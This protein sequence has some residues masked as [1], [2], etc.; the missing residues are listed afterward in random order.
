MF[1][2][3]HDLLGTVV[4]E[5][6]DGGARR[7]VG[8]GLPRHCDQR[9]DADVEGGVEAVPAGVGEVAGEVFLLGVCDGMDEDVQIALSGMPAL[10]DAPDLVVVADVAAFHESGADRSRK[11][12][13]SAFDQRSHR[14]EA[15]LRAL[16]VQRLGDPP[17]DRVVVGDAKTR[18]FLPLS[19]PLLSQSSAGR[20]R[21]RPTRGLATATAWA[22]GAGEEVES[23]SAARAAGFSVNLM[24]SVGPPSIP[25]LRPSPPVPN[26]GGPDSLRQSSGE[27][28]RTW[29]VWMGVAAVG[30]AR[31]RRLWSPL[32]LTEAAPLPTSR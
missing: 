20:A 22:R 19:R 10:E 26:S 32:P 17:G 3:R 4:S 25:R 27:P 2:V 9:V 23:C 7:H 6:D 28:F 13:N 30:A 31:S 16:L 14:A 29:N 8:A 18:A 1:V 11:R 24:G 21:R 15:D 5:G 12:P